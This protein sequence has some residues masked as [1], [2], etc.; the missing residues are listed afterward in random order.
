MRPQRGLD[1]HSG[2]ER[3]AWCRRRMASMETS[4]GWLALRL[5]ALG[6][7]ELRLRSALELTPAAAAAPDGWPRAA[8]SRARSPAKEI[9]PRP[10]TCCATRRRAV[11]GRRTSRPTPSLRARSCASPR[12]GRRRALTISCGSASCMAEPQERPRFGRHRW[13]SRAAL[14][15]HAL[16]RGDEARAMLA[17]ELERAQRSARP[18]R[19]ANALRAVGIVEG[20]RRG[21]ELLQ[22]GGRVLDGSPA[23]LERASVTS[24]SEP[25]CAATISAAPR[26]STSRP[27]CG[28][29]SAAGA[30]PLAQR[31][32]DELAGLRP[33]ASPRRPRRPRRAHTVRAA[34]RPTRRQG[35]HQPR[36]RGALYLSIKTVEMHLGRDVP[37]ARHPG[38]AQ[39]TEALE[40]TVRPG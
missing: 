8:C 28:S 31:A 25:R 17:G 12:A 4:R 36:D 16:G 1:A 39:L 27:D 33:A 19:S 2:C 18:S 9:S 15:L 38:R 34:H 6:E 11:A 22:R 14:A 13:R 26:A 5:G 32:Y 10:S 30:R 20:G 23:A 37:Q 7:A 24:S 29:R 3:C 40:R 35:P 21:L